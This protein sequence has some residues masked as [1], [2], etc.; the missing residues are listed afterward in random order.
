MKTSLS[1]AW[2]NLQYG[3]WRGVQKC[4]HQHPPGKHQLSRS[5]LCQQLLSPAGASAGVQAGAQGGLPNCLPQPQECQGQLG[6]RMEG[7]ASQCRA[8]HA[9]GGK[10][11][12]EGN[13]AILHIL[14]LHILTKDIFLRRQ[15][16][17]NTVQIRRQVLSNPRRIFL[18][19]LGGTQE[20]DRSLYSNSYSNSSFKS[21]SFNSNNC[22]SN[23]SS[24]SSSQQCWHLGFLCQACWPCQDLARVEKEGEMV[25]EGTGRDC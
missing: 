7:F 25:L 13:G 18:S 5:H 2:R 10:V 21:C 20:P 23:N 1:G 11:W 6:L 4:H 9:T 17:W 8:G 3:A 14:T 19:M 15:W 16:R 24:H 22:N 12:R